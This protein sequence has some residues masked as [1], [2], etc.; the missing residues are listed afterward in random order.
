MLIFYV[1]LAGLFKENKLIKLKGVSSFK[2]FFPLSSYSRSISILISLIYL[3]YF[4][5]VSL[6]HLQTALVLFLRATCA[7]RNSEVRDPHCGHP[8]I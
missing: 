4:K 1:N 7:S 5:T 3:E 8:T 2:L 6:V